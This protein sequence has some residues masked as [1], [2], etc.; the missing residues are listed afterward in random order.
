MALIH[1]LNK[2]E[3]C[4]GSANE[5]DDIELAYVKKGFKQ[6][7]AEL[8]VQRYYDWDERIELYFQT[9][10]CIVD[11]AREL[12][13]SKG[14]ISEEEFELLSKEAMEIEIIDV[15]SEEKLSVFL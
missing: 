6:W 2:F 15:W 1:V 9:E 8:V 7:V 4:Q 13:K 5:Y 11:R 3:A 14:F 10:K 12:V